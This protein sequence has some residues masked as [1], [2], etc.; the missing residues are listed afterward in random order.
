MLS[1]CLMY[2]HFTYRTADGSLVRM[3]KCLLYA[4]EA[5]GMIT[6]GLN[7]PLHEEL[8]RSVRTARPPPP[9]CGSRAQVISQLLDVFLSYHSRKMLG[10]S[11]LP[12]TMTG[13]SMCR[14]S[15]TLLQTSGVAVAVTAMNGTLLGRARK[16]PIFL[17]VH[18]PVLPR[19]GSVIVR[20]KKVTKGF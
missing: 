3:N 5:K 2:F 13:F 17:T 14:A 11:R 20:C 12:F 15:I 8:A 18:T 10:R 4:F 16:L 19:P 6:R 9:P 7:S 1:S